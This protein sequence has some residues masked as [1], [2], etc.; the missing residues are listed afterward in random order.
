MMGAERFYDSALSIC[1]RKNMQYTNPHDFVANKKDRLAQLV[2]RYIDIVEATSSSLVSVTEARKSRR[3]LRG[4][5][6]FLESKLLC[7]RASVSGADMFFSIQEKNS[8]AGAASTY[9]R[10]E[11][12]TCATN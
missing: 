1:V 5:G 8:R 3:P 10:S 9:E 4:G 7:F 11:L 2:E 12:V 6:F